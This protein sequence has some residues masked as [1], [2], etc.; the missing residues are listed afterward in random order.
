LGGLDAFIEKK[1]RIEVDIDGDEK[2]IPVISTLLPV[3]FEDLRLE[4]SGAGIPGFQFRIIFKTDSWGNIARLF[5]WQ[6]PET[7]PNRNLWNMVRGVRQ[8]LPTTGPCLPVFTIPFYNELF[9]ASDEEEVNRILKLGQNGLR[10]RNL[11]DLPSLNAD[12]PLRPLINDLSHEFGL[13]LKALDEEGFFDAVTTPWRRFKGKYENILKSFVKKDGVGPD[14]Q[15]APLMYKAFSIISEKDLSSPFERFLSTAVLTGM[16]PALLEMIT[17]RDT[18]LVHGFLSKVDMIISDMSGLKVNLQQWNDVCDLAKI[19]YPLYGLISDASKRLNTTIQSHGLIHCLG[20]PP[21]TSAPLSAKMLLRT[22]E[23]DED[24]I[25]DTVL[26]RENRESRV[27]KRFLEEYVMVYPHAADG[28]S[29]AVVN[30]DSFQPIIAGI[31][32]FLKEQV[33][34]NRTTD[35]E[36]PY[37]FSFTLFTSDNQQQEAAR[38]LQEWKKRWELARETAKFAYYKNCRLSIAH[39]VSHSIDDYMKLI[40]RSDFE[41]DVAILMNFITAGDAGN[42]V[43]QS[44][45]FKVDRGYPLKFPIVETPRCSEDQPGRAHVRAKVIS[46]RRF[47]LATL[48]SELGVYF[49]HHDYPLG[50]EYI[51]ISEGNYGYWDKLIEKLHK[52]ATWVICLDPAI[53]EKLTRNEN[54]SGYSPREI[55]GFSSGLGFR[56][57]LNY[58]LS[59]ERSSLADVE[60][61]VAQQLNRICGPWNSDILAT[62]SHFL[63]SKSR[64][65]SGLSL[66]RATGPG[67]KNIRDL[68]SSTLVRITLPAPSKKGIL[69]C[70]E[71][72]S[73]DAFIHWF[74]TAGDPERP[75]LL[76]IVAHLQDTGQVK[77]NAHI[78]ECKLAQENSDHLNKAHVQLESGLRHLMGVF[79]PREDDTPQ[80]F[81]QRYWW[82][83]LQRLVASKSHVSSSQ[84]ATVTHALELLGEGKF[85]ICWQAMAVAYW[86]DNGKASYELINQWDF[87]FQN[88]Q[89]SIDVICAGTEII[90]PIC[91]GEDNIKIPCSSSNVCFSTQKSFGNEANDLS[92]F[93]TEFSRTDW[94]EEEKTPHTGSV[95]HKQQEVQG[96]DEQSVPDKKLKENTQGNGKPKESDLVEEESDNE[97]TVQTPKF[98]KRIFL[99]E[100]LGNI[101]REVYWEFGNDQLENRHLLIFGKSGV[102]KTYAIQAIIME[103]AKQKQHA[104]IVDYTSGFLT[105]HL[106]EIFKEVIHPKGHIV[107][108]TPLPINPFRRQRMVI[109][110]FKDIEDA[111]SVAGRITSVFT[112][113]YSSFGEQQK[114]LLHKIIEQGIETYSDGYDFGKLLEDLESEDNT[115]ATTVANKLTPLGR[116]NLFE[117][118]NENSWQEIYSDPVTNVNILQLAGLS[119]DLAKMATEFILWDLY[120]FAS[121]QGSKD[122][123]LPMVL[124]EIQNLDHRLDS[125][126]AK[127]LTEGRKFG[128]SAILATQTLSNLTQEAQSRLFMASHKLFFRPA[129]TELKEYATILSNATSENVNIWKDKLV[130]LNKGECYS[131]GLSLNPKTN[132]L[133]EKAFPIRITALAERINKGCING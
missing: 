95:T 61:V 16:H 125:P 15:F 37:H 118:Q 18:F 65:L 36:L 76:R 114:A 77:I 13:F 117:G 130:A 41:A 116:A 9:L 29:L 10:V 85:T 33:G 69:L 56:G 86:T 27:I 133:E 32:S 14:N 54:N 92:D 115:N 60:R 83:Q 111:Y 87:L 63:V 45:P 98:P 103:L 131:L 120:D 64:L 7:Q 72:I 5:Q 62:T 6:L 108:K 2:N 84:Q 112:S 19:K 11:L 23:N 113:V 28:I 82:A 96:E 35:T 48:H 80:Q 102:G 73:L 93:D 132:K 88:I 127:F 97:G 79:Y 40:S 42:D 129:D 4:R 47:R 122:T 17:N 105:S 58:T 55:I 70:D 20:D 1:L 104:A 106:E 110:D 81:D 67:E 50:R 78:I 99:G 46:N 3:N 25:T 8:L 24:D 74:D 109:D 89:L 100:T 121:N 119:R 49:K 101:K 22:D 38:H 39:R 107:K 124:D 68:I 21:Q 31:N 66:V 123:P 34:T 59:T 128:L 52:C 44:A 90:I 30:P 126:L 71:L 43:E 57:E 51:V 26:F 53:D 12:D 91:K 75:D 94:H